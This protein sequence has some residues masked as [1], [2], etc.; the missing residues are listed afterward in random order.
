MKL[1]AMAAHQPPLNQMWSESMND[2]GFEYSPSFIFIFSS[3]FFFCN[4]L[5]SLFYF[6]LFIC[7][8]RFWKFILYWIEEILFHR[9]ICLFRSGIMTTTIVS[10]PEA[11]ERNKK[12]LLVKSNRKNRKKKWNQTHRNRFINRGY[13]IM[14][15]SVA[16]LYMQYHQLYN[17]QMLCLWFFYLVSP[18]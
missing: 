13:V 14:A 1:L 2:M 17:V 15:H 5:V 9:F 18:I 8:S 16:M 11:D 6:P 3:Y 7:C 4:M 10:Q 12:K